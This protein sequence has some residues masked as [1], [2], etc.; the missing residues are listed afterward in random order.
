MFVR[1]II[2]SLVT[3]MVFSGCVE[4]EEPD[5]P[6]MNEGSKL[7][8]RALFNQLSMNPYSTEA[9]HIVKPLCD[10]LLRLPLPHFLGRLSWEVKEFYEY[11]LRSPEVRY[12]AFENPFLRMSLHLRG[13]DLGDYRA[14]NNSTRLAVHYAVAAMMVVKC[15]KLEEVPSTSPTAPPSL[16]VS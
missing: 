10:D 8:I 14:F 7:Q 13:A 12:S 6:G 15:I 3:A 16:P 2:L 11:H 9:M 1:V 4:R 5:Y